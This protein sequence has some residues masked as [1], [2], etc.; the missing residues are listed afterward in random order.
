MNSDFQ[1]RKRSRLSR[2]VSFRSKQKRYS[3]RP[4]DL[5]IESK[6]LSENTTNGKKR[7]HHKNELDGSSD[8]EDNAI[9]P[10]KSDDLDASGGGVHKAIR[11]TNL[12]NSAV[13]TNTGDMMTTSTSEEDV[14]K[15]PSEM[16][17]IRSKT[18]SPRDESTS[19][20][21]ASSTGSGRRKFGKLASGHGKPVLIPNMEDNIQELQQS[22]NNALAFCFKVF[23]REK[24]RGM[25]AKD[26]KF[27]FHLESSLFTLH[28]SPSI[29]P[30]T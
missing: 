17:I 26:V 23:S 13:N 3:A 5:Y 6:N 21:D 14:E 16:R 4:T 27:S 18:T 24:E 9:T 25:K 15:M 22:A 20:L 29:R 28:L 11:R 2:K 12:F 19:N 10:K 8:P 7:R 30:S 1:E